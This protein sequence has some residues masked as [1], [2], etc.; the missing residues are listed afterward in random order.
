MRGPWCYAH[1]QPAALRIE[2]PVWIVKKNCLNR[3]AT[4]QLDEYVGFEAIKNE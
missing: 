1:A 3:G 4:M 2:T